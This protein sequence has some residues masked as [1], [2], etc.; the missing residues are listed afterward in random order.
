MA[1]LSPRPTS[2]NLR[3][4]HRLY[5]APEWALLTEVRN[6]TGVHEVLRVADAIAVQLWGGTWRVHGFELKTSRADWLRELRHPEKC[7]PL[8]AFCSAWYL[9]TPAPWKRVV[10]SLTELPDR[11]GLIEIGTG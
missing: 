5:A 7:G 2:G 9:V 1:K 4:L 10:M 8:K 3:S 6:A 11:W